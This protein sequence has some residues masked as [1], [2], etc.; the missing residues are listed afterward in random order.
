[1]QGWNDIFFVKN[2]SPTSDVSPFH[3]T[4]IVCCKKFVDFQIDLL[5]KTESFLLRT[6]DYRYSWTRTDVD[7]DY[8]TD[9]FLEIYYISDNNTDN[10]GKMTCFNFLFVKLR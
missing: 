3:A 5:V 6:V 1:M 4:C 10:K 8:K 2:T 7:F 9:D